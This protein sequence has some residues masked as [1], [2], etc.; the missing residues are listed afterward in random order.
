MAIRWM[1][2]GVATG[3]LKGTEAFQS[4]LHP[5]CSAGLIL[6][7]PRS[8]S[9]LQQPLGVAGE[10]LGLSSSH[11]GTDSI[12]LVPGGF[13]TNGQ[14]TANRMRSMPISITQHNSAG[15]EKLPLVVT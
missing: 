5:N 14:S 15:L 2:Y 4:S 11:S 7:S 8:A 6:M 9:H 10:D 12:H 1:L 3:E 13:G